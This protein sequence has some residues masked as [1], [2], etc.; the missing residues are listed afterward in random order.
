MTSCPS[1]RAITAMLA[2]ACTASPPAHQAAETASSTSQVS[3]TA[4]PQ[5]G[6]RT[7]VATTWADPSPLAAKLA[8]PE[9]LVRAVAEAMRTED[10]TAYVA[11]T[12]ST[13]ADFAALSATMS[14]PAP[15]PT[16][17][18]LVRSRQKQAVAF[19]SFLATLRERGVEI[20]TI[21]PTGIDVSR[22]ATRGSMGFA[23][24]LSFLV[25]TT[26]GEEIRVTID[27][28]VLAPRGWIVVD[29]LKLRPPK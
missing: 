14:R 16:A 2:T 7:S 26:S 15:G 19:R 13:E 27:D 18:Q 3:A 20:R 1:V 4:P 12:V 25:R 8:T 5:H 6:A 21:T 28:C 17:E 29:G 22:A 11:L 24:D 23:E 10:E 9:G